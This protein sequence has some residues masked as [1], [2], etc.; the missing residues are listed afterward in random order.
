MKCP[1]CQAEMLK[2]KVCCDGRMGI[3]FEKDGPHHTLLEKR[4]AR[5]Y[6]TASKGRLWQSAAEAHYCSRC[7]KMLIDTDLD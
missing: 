6:L 1:Y 5:R 4:A 2:G 7:R 3:W